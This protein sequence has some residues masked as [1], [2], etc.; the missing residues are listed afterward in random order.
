MK[1][2]Q[3]LNVDIIRQINSFIFL[4]LYICLPVT[5]VAKAPQQSS[6]HCCQHHHNNLLSAGKSNSSCSCTLNP[7]NLPGTKVP[8]CNCHQP[9]QITPIEQLGTSTILVELKKRL[10]HKGGC[11]LTKQEKQE[12]FK[13][14]VAAYNNQLTLP[15]FDFDNLEEGRETVRTSSQFLSNMAL[16]WAIAQKDP[17]L[18]N[19]II[20]QNEISPH[21]LNE[22][23]MEPLGWALL[24]F[25]ISSLEGEQKARDA[26]CQTLIT[27]GAKISSS[28]PFKNTYETPLLLAAK[29][30]MYS[31]VQ[32]F[33]NH[34]STS[35]ANLNAP[36]S[37][38]EKLLD[39]L[40]KHRA[41]A[42][43]E[44]IVKELINISLQKGALASPFSSSSPVFSAAAQIVQ[45]TPS[46]HA[47]TAYNGLIKP[48]KDR[49]KTYLIVSE[50]FLAGAVLGAFSTLGYEIVI[51]NNKKK[52]FPS[53]KKALSNFIKNE[54]SWVTLGASVIS[55]AACIYLKSELSSMEK[56]APPV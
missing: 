51:Y 48:S 10:S 2:K 14:G 26:I 12:L 11:T 3:I 45:Q 44:E 41:D 37:A 7:Q 4:S 55:G 33:A 50:I 40:L 15:I 18:V 29:K 24:I 20:D 21:C 49:A 5:G 23:G 30:K 6:C 22:F 34:P 53:C 8:P 9:P 16:F 56:Q 35:L 1:R 36:N 43:T 25:S 54:F 46:E 32:M 52:D 42:P 47:K 17:K 31:L 13:L 19:F 39:V 28:I 27:R 38:G